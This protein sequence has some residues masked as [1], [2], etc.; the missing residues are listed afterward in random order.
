MRNVQKVQKV[1]LVDNLK[2][3]FKPFE[4]QMEQKLKIIFFP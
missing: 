3:I 1:R 2:M 4:L